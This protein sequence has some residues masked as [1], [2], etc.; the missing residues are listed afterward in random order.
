[1]GGAA[2][3]MFGLWSSKISHHSQ[4]LSGNGTY[5][6]TSIQSKGKKTISFILAYIAV[7]KGTNIGIESV[8]AQQVTI[9]EK[10]T[11]KKNPDHDF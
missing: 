5:T 8:Y 7:S 11:L 9:Y 1:M 3:L 4:D 10:L 2:I 6:I